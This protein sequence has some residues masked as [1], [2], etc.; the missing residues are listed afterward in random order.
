MLRQLTHERKQR[1]GL[2]ERRL[3]PRRLAPVQPGRRG[4]VGRQRVLAL[5]RAEPADRPRRADALALQQ[6]LARGGIERRLRDAERAALDAPPG[7]AACVRRPRSNTPLAALT[8]LNE[9]LFLDCARAVVLGR[10]D[11][12]TEILGRRP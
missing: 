10:P 6:Q 9:P 12:T 3:G 8:S 7:E 4:D 1:L 5:G 11:G 2:R